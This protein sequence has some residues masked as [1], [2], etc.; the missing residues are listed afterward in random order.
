MRSSTGRTRRISLGRVN[1]RRFAFARRH[2]PAGGGRAARRRS[3]PERRREAARRPRVRVGDRPRARGAAGTPRA[4]AR[5]RG[6]RARGAAPSSPTAARTRTPGG[7]PLPIAREAEFDRRPRSRRAG[8]GRAG[9]R[10]RRTAARVLSGRARRRRFLRGH[11]LDRIEIRC[12]VPL[13]LHVDGEDLGDV[14]QAT[15]RPSGRPSRSSSDGRRDPR[16]VTP[17][18]RRNLASGARPS[19]GLREGWVA[20]GRRSFAH[21]NF[22]GPPG[23]VDCHGG[24]GVGVGGGHDD[25][26]EGGDD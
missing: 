14:E 5:D 26:A 24:I 9:A 16:L 13:P 19:C 11:D 20:R 23:G 2:R 4:A 7:C 12:D 15:S 3:R 25:G 6:L 22:L 8:R 21:K 10:C 18:F 1:G 17:S